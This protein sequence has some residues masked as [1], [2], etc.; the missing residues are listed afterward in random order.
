MFI[1]K[2]A[3]ELWGEFQIFW[4]NNKHE[5]ISQNYEP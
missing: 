1:D 4:L 5:N 2:L 3:N